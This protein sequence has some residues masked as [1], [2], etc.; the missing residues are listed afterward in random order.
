MHDGQVDQQGVAYIRHIRRVADAVSDVAKPVAMFHDAIEDRRID[1]EELR[2]LLTT[3][4]YLAV[5]PSRVT[6]KAKAM[7]S[8]SRGSRE[9]GASP[10]SS[11]AT[12]RSRTSETTSVASRPSSSACARDTRLLSNGSGARPAAGSRAQLSTYP[13]WVAASSAR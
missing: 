4:E 7:P 11:P 2:A 3:D 6:R 13:G 5:S 10:G 8:S 12:S 1:P 9:P